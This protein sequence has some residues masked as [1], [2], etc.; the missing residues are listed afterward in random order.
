[1]PAPE[2]AAGLDLHRPERGPVATWASGG[3]NVYGVLH[4]EALQES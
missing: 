1:M 2:G 3:L 4:G